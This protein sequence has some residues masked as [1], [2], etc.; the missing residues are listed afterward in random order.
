MVSEDNKKILNGL[1]WG[2]SL[3][4]F[5]CLISGASHGLGGPQLGYK[6]LSFRTVFGAAV[7]GAIAFPLVGL[8]SNMVKEKHT[9]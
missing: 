4:I 2:A 6:K 7:S 3:G 8:A 1:G 9:K 5:G